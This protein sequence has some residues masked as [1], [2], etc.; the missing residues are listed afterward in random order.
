[1][2]VFFIDAHGIHTVIIEMIDRLVR[3]LMVQENILDDMNK[4]GVSIIS[5][6]RWRPVRK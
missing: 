5:V 2:N 6:N 3:D 1:M 4:N